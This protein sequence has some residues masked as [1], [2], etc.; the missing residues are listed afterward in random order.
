MDEY[1]VLKKSYQELRKKV[2]TEQF[3]NLTDSDIDRDI[4]KECNEIRA[5]LEDFCVTNG[6]DIKELTRFFISVEDELI[7]TNA[8]AFYGC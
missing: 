5:Q 6:K 8:S 1:E 2:V 7:N 4:N 3:N